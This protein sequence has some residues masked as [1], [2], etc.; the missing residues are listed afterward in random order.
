[1]RIVRA[2]DFAFTPPHAVAIGNFDGMHI[3]H[4]RVITHL[5]ALGRERGLNTAVLSFYPHPA[6]TAGRCP[7]YKVLL[8]RE[9]KACLLAESGVDAYIEYPFDSQTANMPPEAFV[10]EVLRKKLNS[11]HIVVGEDFRFGHKAAGD[12]SILKELCKERGIEVSALKTIAPKDVD[13]GKISAS[14]IKELILNKNI[15]LANKLL[16]REYSIGGFYNPDN[17]VFSV[18]SPE[19]IMP[20]DGLYAVTIIRNGTTYMGEAKL[21]GSEIRLL[22]T[23]SRDVCAGEA[24]VSFR[25]YLM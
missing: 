25:Q 19:K 20:P 10:F 14:H 9:E 15:S 5:T 22:F 6:V 17:G 21:T 23:G 2:K 4:M 3:G 18:S 12:V 8:T 1:M 16:G 11:A 13:E 7:E 24:R